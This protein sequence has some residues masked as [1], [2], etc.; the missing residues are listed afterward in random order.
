MKLK[1][2]AYL[3]TC[4]FSHSIFYLFAAKGHR[5]LGAT[6]HASSAWQILVRHRLP[7]PQDRRNA[8]WG[9]TEIGYNLIVGICIYEY[10]P[11]I[12]QNY[13]K[14][15]FANSISSCL[16]GIC[17]SEGAR[18]RPRGRLP[19]HRPLRRLWLRHRHTGQALQGRCQPLRKWVELT[20]QCN[21][22][23]VYG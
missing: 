20:V 19:H 14:G 9:E 8:Q 15:I 6:D 7:Q 1:L 23:S 16:Q 11:K 12:Y 3:A 4:I 21:D 10:Q 18:P 13:N 5:N 22:S 2:I 17:D